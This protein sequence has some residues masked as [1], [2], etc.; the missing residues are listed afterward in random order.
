[1]RLLACVIPILS[2][3]FPRCLDAWAGSDF[4][5]VAG[6][7]NEEAIVRS[8]PGEE[9]YITDRLP[10]GT[11]VEVFRYDNHEWAAIRPPQ[12]SF[13]WIPAKAVE[14][15]EQPSIG[16]VVHDGVQTRIG[17]VFG[18]DHRSAYIRLD[19]DE[20]VEILEQRKLKTISGTSLEEFYRI[21]PPAGEFRWISIDELIAVDS[22]TEV[23][24]EIVDSRQEILA[25]DLAVPDVE[26]IG[27]PATLAENPP[28]DLAHHDDMDGKESNADAT[29]FREE[30]SVT[31]EGAQLPAPS[32][33]TA[34]L[35][36]DRS[37]SGLSQ[38][39]AA[40][41]GI[42]NAELAS[43]ELNLSETIVDNIG[44][45]DLTSL[46]L[47]TQAVIDTGEANLVREDAQ[48]LL[49]KITQFADIKRR[50]E[51]LNTERLSNFGNRTPGDWPIESEGKELRELLTE[52]QRGNGRQLSKY[53]GEGWLRR[54]VSK[55]RGVPAYALTDRNGNI[56]QFISPQTG[57]DIGQYERKRVGIFGVRGFIPEFDRPH[58][59][60]QRVVTLDK[61]TR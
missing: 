25:P 7:V 44:R 3:V 5:Y 15:T 19:R 61:V 55:R 20:L 43:I 18:D 41:T 56:I 28:T 38:P 57:L 48:Q 21:M 40:T 14:K 26:A 12:G 4:P 9:F 46:Q 24:K 58:L 33:L 42:L 16:R 51:Q 29:R 31:D 23:P 45:W 37:P 54:V 34:A 60:A 2:I 35:D 10:A 30:S 22:P 8:G 6:V 32:V 49:A 1:M 13:S 53:D 27:I 50:S 52:I 17:T 11:E 36:G 39:G 47:R 59:V